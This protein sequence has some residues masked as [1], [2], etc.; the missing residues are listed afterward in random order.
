MDDD[1]YKILGVQRNASPAEI[2]KAYR[3]MASKYHPDLVEDEKDKKRAKQKFQ[4]VQKAYD[5]LS[6]SNKRELYDRYGSSFESMGGGGGGWQAH[7]GG[8]GGFEDIDFSQVFGGRGGGA[9]ASPFEDIFAQFTRGGDPRGRTRA[10]PR[11]GGNVQHTIRVPFKTAI[12]GGEAR[13]AV[14]RPDGKV[15]NISVK[16]PQGIEEGKELR[17]RGQ[18]EPSPNGGPSGDMLIT[19]DIDAHP[20]FKRRE[21]DLIVTVPVTLAEAAFGTKVDV[22]SPKGTI[23]VTIP[24]GTSSGKRLRVK[25]YGVTTA[26]GAQGDLY[27]EIQIELPEHLDEESQNLIREFDQQTDLDPRSGLT[28]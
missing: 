7:P 16:I 27:A 15:E 23:T 5:V 1:Y 9:G 8:G 6:D 4:E 11:R 10:A 12:I 22:P 14:R 28:W 25:G 17:L 26:K 19:V 2:Q 21:N 13:L 18:G 3:K 24:S 20:H